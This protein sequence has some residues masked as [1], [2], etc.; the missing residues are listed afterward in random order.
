MTP[1]LIR[2][3]NMM[4]KRSNQP[5]VLRSSGTGLKANRPD[6]G[7]RRLGRGRGA[8]VVVGG[9]KGQIRKRW[10]PLADPNFPVQQNK[11]PPRV[12]PFHWGARRDP[13]MGS[14]TRYPGPG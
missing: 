7:G 4:L 1:G 13:T 5:A 6:A 8:L 14:R 10:G 2:K 3:L 12:F 9:G 11:Q